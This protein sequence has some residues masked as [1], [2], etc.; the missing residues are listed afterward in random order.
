V[1]LASARDG[2][3]GGSD[4][5]D[6]EH[7]L[8]LRRAG[9]PLAELDGVSRYPTAL[10]GMRAGEADVLVEV[11]LSPVEDGEPGLSHM[12]EALGRGIAV[13]AS[14]KWPVALAGI[15]LRQ[16]ARA[17]G[18]IFRAE[19]TV[20]SGTPVLGPLTDGLAGARPRRI[21]GVLNA[22]N[23]FIL[24]RMREGERYGA[25]LAQAQELG[26]AEP[27][28]SA[29]V[30]G[31]DTASKL[32]VLS[33]FV[34]GER[35]ALERIERRGISAVSTAETGAGQVSREVAT[36]DPGAG[37]G[38]VSPEALDR[39]GPL[40][41]AEGTTNVLVCEA[42]PLGSI[43]ITGPGAGPELAGQGALSDLIAIERELTRAGQGAQASRSATSSSARRA[44]T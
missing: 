43:V 31:I 39:G 37:V 6:L 32:M 35:L 23:N 34:F 24:T 21:R 9:R 30:D 26:L 13:V 3:V 38:G 14:N 1:G 25:A 19:S 17:N 22:T 20:M 12:R 15:E 18:T 33:A 44:A 16:L 2:F 29:D 8:R 4:D 27:D 10:A 11:G 42:E 7:A 28:P 41:A 5:I 40:V 36:L